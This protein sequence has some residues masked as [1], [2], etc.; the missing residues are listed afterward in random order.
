MKIAKL[1][2]LVNV[3]VHK[4]VVKGLAVI[5]KKTFREAGDEG[6]TLP[7]IQASIQARRGTNCQGTL[8]GERVVLQLVPHGLAP[9]RFPP[10][11]LR[12]LPHL[13]HQLACQNQKV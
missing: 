5:P 12:N 1:Q 2:Y 7:D 6:I 13:H 9:G 10:E 3:D 11:G 8:L 4:Q